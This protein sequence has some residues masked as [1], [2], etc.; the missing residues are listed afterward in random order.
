MSVELPY[1]L[2]ASGASVA[3][4]CNRESV[5]S[6]RSTLVSFFLSY[7]SY[8]DKKRILELYQE[9]EESFEDVNEEER[10]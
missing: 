1:R 4:R 10:R 5:P 6:L 2:P 8:T 3:Y 7:F 9:G